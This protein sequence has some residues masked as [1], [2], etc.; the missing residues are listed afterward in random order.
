MKQ[1][2]TRKQLVEIHGQHG[3]DTWK[4]LIES[5]LDDNISVKD[6]D[7]ID[8]QKIFDYISTGQE[9]TIFLSMIEDKL[10]NYGVFFNKKRQ[11]A[12]DLFWKLFNSCTASTCERDKSNYITYSNKKGEWLFTTNKRYRNAFEISS[13]RVHKLFQKRLGYHELATAS[14]V[15]LIMKHDSRF[16]GLLPV[17]LGDDLTQDAPRIFAL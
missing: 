1:T 17:I 16:T 10:E 2:L 14:I 5:I 9:G 15:R 7:E 8:I 13:E 12:H 6:E 4:K 11:K 3:F